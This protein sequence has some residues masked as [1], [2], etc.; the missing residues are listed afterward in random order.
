MTP[1][2]P[3]ETWAGTSPAPT[4]VYN[5]IAEIRLLKQVLAQHPEWTVACKDSLNGHILKHDWH[6]HLSGQSVQGQ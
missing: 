6:I 5:L 2:L 3:L 4:G 1:R